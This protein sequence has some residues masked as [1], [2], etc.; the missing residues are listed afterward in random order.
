MKYLLL[1]HLDDKVW[2][3]MPKDE[4]DRIGAGCDAYDEG[5]RRDGRL[6]FVQR[7]HRTGQSRQDIVY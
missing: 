3:R 2:E 4:A 1:F 7:L 5:L 6:K